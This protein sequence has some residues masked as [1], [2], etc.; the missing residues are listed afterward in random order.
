MGDRYLHFVIVVL[1]ALDLVYVSDSLWPPPWTVA[2]QAPLPWGVPGKNTGVGCH[3]LLQGIFLT[4][5][6]NLGLLHCRRYPYRLSHR[7]VHMPGLSCHIWVL[8]SWPGIEP[9]PPA[10]QVQIAHGT[11][12]HNWGWPHTCRTLLPWGAHTSSTLHDCGVRGEPHQVKPTIPTDNCIYYS[13]LAKRAFQFKLSCSITYPRIWRRKW[14]GISCLGNAMNR[15]A[16]W[17]TI[18]GIEKEPDMTEQANITFT[19]KHQA[20]VL[21]KSFP[22]ALTCIRTHRGACLWCTFLGRY[23]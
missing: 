3:V 12:K 20:L 22:M 23:P 11:T 4:Q 5:G 21:Y 7:E 16:W 2:L 19:S 10:L 14:H 6:L 9:R 1:A 13:W 8:V 17:A 18:H 15:G